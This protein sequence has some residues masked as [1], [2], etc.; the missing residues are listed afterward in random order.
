[1]FIIIPVYI[2][3]HIYIHHHHRHHVDIF[4]TKDSYKSLEPIH[5][6][7]LPIMSDISFT[8]CFYS[9]N[10]HTFLPLGGFSSIFP[11]I[12]SRNTLSSLILYRPTYFHFFLCTSS[13]SIIC[14]FF[15]S[16]SLQYLRC[17]PAFIKVSTH[18][19]CF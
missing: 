12:V 3:I 13:I 11:R 19:E 5:I 4:L 10:F 6:S 15:C 2:H 16:T 17:P 18:L 9:R 1:M 7:L 8:C 14:V